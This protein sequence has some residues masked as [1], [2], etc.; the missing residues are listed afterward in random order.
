MAAFLPD[1]LCYEY[2]YPIRILRIRPSAP[3][4]AEALTHRD[5]LG[6]VLNLGIDRCKIGDFI[7]EENA[8][9]VF[10]SE[11]V[12]DYI[13]GSLVRVRHT[14]VTVE[15]V[16]GEKPEITLNFRE[17]TGTVASVRLDAVLALAFSLSRSKLTGLIEGGRVFVN[18][19]LVTSNGYR[20]KEGD[21]ISLRGMGRIAYNGV[22]S[23]TRK[24]RFQ[25][26]VSK[27]I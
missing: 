26:S 13:A 10:V 6:A 18:G 1:A 24:G 11:S 4:F 23:S 14:N 2:H 21:I 25:I 27:Y 22:L 12:A 9:T 17:I 7:V 16:S 19:K 5:Y 20:L 8:C 3:K 15:P